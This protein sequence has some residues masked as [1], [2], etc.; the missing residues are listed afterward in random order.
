MC[1]VELGAI[2]YSNSVLLGEE[3]CLPACT[4]RRSEGVARFVRRARRVRSVEMDVFEGMLRGIA[5][6]VVSGVL[7]LRVG[8]GGCELRKTYW[9][10]QRRF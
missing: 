3:R 7:Q 4:S 9:C 10:R 5:V 6:M 2:E 1:S 8:F